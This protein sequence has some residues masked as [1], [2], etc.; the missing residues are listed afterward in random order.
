MYKNLDA[1]GE[2]TQFR[3]NFVSVMKAWEILFFLSTYVTATKHRLL[4]V[5]KQKAGE[6]CGSIFGILLF[7][8]PVQL[9]P[10]ETPCRPPPPPHSRLLAGYLFYAVVLRPTF[11]YNSNFEKII[12]NA[13]GK[14]E[15]II[16][17]H[18]HI[19]FFKT[20]A[21]MY[22]TFLEVAR[23]TSPFFDR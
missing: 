2:N 9:F 22:P 17:I 23:H 8:S 7:T 11:T 21:I 20:F 16:V 15:Y 4:Q 19:S 14:G 3:R 6:L 5:R 12:C 1:F 18:L 10:V 13:K